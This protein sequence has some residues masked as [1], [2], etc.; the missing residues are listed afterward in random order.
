M[1]PDRAKNRR[2]SRNNKGSIH[3]PIRTW[4]SPLRFTHQS[5][6]RLQ[7]S[8]SCL[9]PRSLLDAKQLDLPAST[10]SSS[11]LQGGK[12]VELLGFGIVREDRPGF[13][14]SRKGRTSKNSIGTYALMDRLEGVLSSRKTLSRLGLLRISPRSVPTLCL[15]HPSS[16]PSFLSFHPPTFR[17]RHPVL[18]P[19]Q[20]LPPP[21]SLLQEHFFL[22]LN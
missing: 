7:P 16:C 14:D 8:S 21:I 22:V 9:G 5:A 2:L 13:Q 4:P 3:F 12:P 20:V 15:A 1:P 19:H 6:S 10:S 18:R 17:P 11:N